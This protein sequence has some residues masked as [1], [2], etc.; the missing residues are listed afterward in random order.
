MFGS[1]GFYEL[2]FI[3][4]ISIPP[5]ILV[6]VSNRIKGSKKFG[7]FLVCLFLSWLGYGLFLVLTDKK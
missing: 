7:W 1:F 2:I 6:L 5:I 4:M 3:F